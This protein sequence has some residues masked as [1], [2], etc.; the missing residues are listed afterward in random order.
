[1]AS[2]GLRKMLTSLTPEEDGS[3]KASVFRKPRHTDLYVK[4][5]S[6]HNIP[7]KHSVAGTLYN[8]AKT[9]CFNPQ[10][11]Q[12][13]EKHLSQ[14]LRRCNYPTWAIN[15]AK[16]RS[17][18]PN[19]QQEEMTTNLAKMTTIIRTYTWWFH[20]IKGLVRG[21]KNHATNLGYKSTSKEDRLSR[22]SL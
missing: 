3:L 11:L 7:S 15:R 4:W 21:S 22:A 2:S 10:L 9:V 19:T 5:N 6:H 16:L 18:N 14:A 17:Q 8:R 1:M 20:I 13:E 12:E